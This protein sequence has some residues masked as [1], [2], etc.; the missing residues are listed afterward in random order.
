MYIFKLSVLRGYSIHPSGVLTVKFN[1]F[2]DVYWI[3]YPNGQRRYFWNIPFIRQA[4]F[5]VDVLDIRR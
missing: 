1:L 2:R 3:L 4:V 5:A